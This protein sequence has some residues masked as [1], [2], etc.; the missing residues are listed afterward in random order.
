MYIVPLFWSVC[1]CVFVC[2]RAHMCAQSCLTLCDPMRIFQPHENFPGKNAWV[3]S[4]FPFLGIFLMQGWK[5]SLLHLLY[6]QVGSL[7]LCYLGSLKHC[8]LSPA[9]ILKCTYTFIIVAIVIS[10]WY[11]D[12]FST[13]TWISLYLEIFLVLKSIL[14]DINVAILLFYGYC[15][16]IYIFSFFCFSQ[17]VSLNLN[18]SLIDNSNRVSVF[19]LE[20]LFTCISLINI[21]GLMPI[22]LFFVSVTCL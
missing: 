21:V 11:V 7:L 16:M 19:W 8:L 13:K 1:V 20:C 2:V 3:G 14:T 15:C 12:P 18:L 6:W 22:S 5:L 17:S 4:H 9:G 10:S